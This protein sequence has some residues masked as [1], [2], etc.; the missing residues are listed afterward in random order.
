MKVSR[1]AEGAVGPGSFTCPFV[2]G[3]VKV[4]NEADM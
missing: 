2:A 4:M 1:G 3:G